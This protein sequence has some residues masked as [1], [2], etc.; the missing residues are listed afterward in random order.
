VYGV[1]YLRR[2]A[3]VA[4]KPVDV[5]ATPA[6]ALLPFQRVGGASGEIGEVTELAE[7]LVDA[8]VELGAFALPA[9][10]AA[11]AGLTVDGWGVAEPAAQRPAWRPAAVEAGLEAV[12]AAVPAASPHQHRNA[13]VREGPLVLAP[14][15]HPDVLSQ[16]MQ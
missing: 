14:R 10:D 12:V 2:S 4:D 7:E 15:A 11:D 5:V 1:R 16:V 6:S 8:P 13:A 9:A 3:E